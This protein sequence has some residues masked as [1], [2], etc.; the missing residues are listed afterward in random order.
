MPYQ[1]MTLMI[2]RRAELDNIAKEEFA[3]DPTDYKNRDEVIDAILGKQE[4]AIKETAEVVAQEMHDGPDPLKAEADAKNQAQKEAL[5]QQVDAKKMA[6]LRPDA[7]KPPAPT[8]KPRDKT[9]LETP[10][11]V[12]I[13]SGPRYWPLAEKM[14]KNL[15]AKGLIDKALWNSELSKAKAQHKDAENKKHHRVKS[16]THLGRTKK[17]NK[18][19]GL[20]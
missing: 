15:G 20:R 4:T 10:I 8:G 7:P 18:V 9:A 14:I 16:N 6:Q 17:I 11:K 2:K 12:Y 13:N 19:R 1:K 5:K 3:L